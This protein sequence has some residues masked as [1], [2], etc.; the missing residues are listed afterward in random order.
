MYESVIRLI[1]VFAM[2]MRGLSYQGVLALFSLLFLF[3][4]CR[5]AKEPKGAK[6]DAD[7]EEVENDGLNRHKFK[8]EG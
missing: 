3:S 5:I 7:V 1:D 6:G 8:V 2:D 4:S